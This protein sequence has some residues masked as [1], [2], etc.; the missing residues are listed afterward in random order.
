MLWVK[1]RCDR[2]FESSYNKQHTLLRKER[3]LCDVM[4]IDMMTVVLRSAAA[5]DFW[6]IFRAR[7]S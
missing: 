1:S 7:H 2:L 3:I 4:P 6:L 5:A